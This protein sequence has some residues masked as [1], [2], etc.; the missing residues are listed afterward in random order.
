MKLKMATLIALA[1]IAP[2][3]ALAA[4]L[5]VSNNGS[6]SNPGTQSAPLQ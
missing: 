6:D 2:A 4:D 1:M 3:W 5:Y